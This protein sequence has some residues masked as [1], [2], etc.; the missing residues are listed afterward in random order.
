MTITVYNNSSPSNK[1]GKSLSTISTL[2]GN[3]R[4]NCSRT[5]PVVTIEADISSLNNA[6]YIYISEF[7][8]YYFITDIVS[9]RNGICEIHA[10]IDVLESFKTDILNSTV[11]TKRQ[12][13]NW[14]LYVD[15]GSFITYS[16]DKMYTMNFPTA[17]DNDTFV[18]VTAGR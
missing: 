14:N 5:N 17:I 10:K 12:R 18:L 15:D 11:I 6:N 16:N 3:L 1:I 13:D 4:D 8:R 2:S 7:S 9:I